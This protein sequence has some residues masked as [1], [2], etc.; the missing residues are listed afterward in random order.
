MTKF[1]QRDPGNEKDR[2]FFFLFVSLFGF[3]EVQNIPVN[4]CRARSFLLL[5]F[6]KITQN[7]LGGEG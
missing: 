5:A 1:Y 2:T 6:L 7:L 3:G 4:L